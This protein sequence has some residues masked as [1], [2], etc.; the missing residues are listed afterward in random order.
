MTSILTLSRVA[1]S[2]ASEAGLVHILKD[3]TLT[4]PASQ[5]VSIMGRR[6]ADG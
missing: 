4:L 5:T 2:L 6:F 3:I 1:L